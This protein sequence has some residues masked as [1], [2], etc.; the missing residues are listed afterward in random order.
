MVKW[1]KCLTRKST[2]RVSQVGDDRTRRHSILHVNAFIH[3]RAL[4]YFT[5]TCGTN[6]CGLLVLNMRVFIFRQRVRALSTSERDSERDDEQSNTRR[7]E[8]FTVHLGS[9][10]WNLR[11]LRKASWIIAI[12]MF[13]QYSLLINNMSWILQSIWRFAGTQLKIMHNIRLVS[14]DVIELCKHKSSLHG[15]VHF[16]TV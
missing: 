1:V 5:N 3:V 6:C 9:S 10:Q 14:A 8:S 4:V 16:V 15:W 7:E 12:E 11:E 2:S 13:Y